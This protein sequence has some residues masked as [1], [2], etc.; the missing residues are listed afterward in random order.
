MAKKSFPL[1]NVYGL[2]E[3]VPVVMVTTA[4]KN[5]T[6]IMTMSWQTMLDFEP[7]IVACVISNRNYSFDLVNASKEC[8]INIPTVELAKKVVKC[9][10]ISGKKIDKF[11]I[12]NLT[13]ETASRVNSTFNW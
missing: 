7:P 2:L 3:P 8:V 13:S 4:Y 11:K 1:A 10:N 6:N 12:L 9:G 5:H